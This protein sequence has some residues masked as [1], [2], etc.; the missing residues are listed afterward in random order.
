MMMTGCR[1]SQ[2]LR[3]YNPRQLGIC[4]FN[5]RK[6]G[7]FC[8]FSGRGPLLPLWPRKFSFCSNDTSYSKRFT[9]FKL[10]GTNA[11]YSSSSVTNNSDDF[12][13]LS[14]VNKDNCSQD[15][16]ED[17]ART[18]CLSPAENGESP[19]SER[20]TSVTDFCHSWTY[21]L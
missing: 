6:H 1:I 19:P 12:A 7:C 16:S 11:S 18:D 13:A 10:S 17:P 14:F 2:Q 21:F 15:T 5:G 4:S 9:R 20:V 8:S 3:E